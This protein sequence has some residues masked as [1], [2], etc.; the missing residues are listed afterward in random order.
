MARKQGGVF[1]LVNH[2]LPYHSSK[3]ASNGTFTYRHFLRSLYGVPNL[4][5]LMIPRHMHTVFRIL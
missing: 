3:E 1:T 2:H 4:Y 5:M